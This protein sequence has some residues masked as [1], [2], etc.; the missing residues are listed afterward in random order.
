MKFSEALDSFMNYSSVH[1]SE[2]THKYYIGKEKQLRTIFGEKNCIDIDRNMIV[3]FIKA[4]RNRNPNITNATVN[5]F[6]AMLK[7]ILK[8]E[9]QI[10]VP[11]PKLRE[12]AKVI[13]IIPDNII[14]TIFSY[15][16]ANQNTS[17]KQRNFLLFKMLLD[18]GL[19]INELLNVR[20]Q[21]IDFNNHTILVKVTKTKRER[22]TFFT[23]N[24]HIILSKYIM[25]NN[26]TEY[27]FIDF[28][29]GNLLTVDNIETV[30]YRLKLK[31][32]LTRPINP[33][34]WRHTFATNFLRKSD[35][36]EVLRLILGHTNI[37]TTQRY[38]HLDKEDIR[39]EYFKT[40]NT[41]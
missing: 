33:H 2:G 35:N 6:I 18:T 10:E 27:L 4:Q 38:L 25:G 19:R 12:I 11:Y 16:M 13:P 39:K 32:N 5:K 14:N 29:S 37:L 30:C 41:L 21:D 31:L 17:A 28:R 9:C 23:P 34:R 40:I 8:I 1:N 26:I 22:Y 20:I 36:L 24:T 15:Y 3:D 7:Y